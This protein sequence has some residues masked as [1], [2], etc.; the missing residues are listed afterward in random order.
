MPLWLAIPSFAQPL[1]QTIY[2]GLLPGGNQT[3]DA[4]ATIRYG[5]SDD[6]GPVV[7]RLGPFETQ[8]EVSKIRVNGKNLANAVTEQ[9]GDSWWVKFTA[10]VG[11]TK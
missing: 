11:S 3:S 6:I 5:A 2:R 7:M 10:N 9:S 8:P 4:P 1:D